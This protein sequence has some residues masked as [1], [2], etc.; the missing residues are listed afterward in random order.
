MANNIRIQDIVSLIV[1]GAGGGIAASA[2]DH[3]GATLGGNIMLGGIVF[4]MGTPSKYRRFP[5]N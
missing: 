3:D 2:D 1:Q 5:A 4:Q